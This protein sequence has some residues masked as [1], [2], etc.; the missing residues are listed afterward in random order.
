MLTASRRLS[1]SRNTIRSGRLTFYLA[2]AAIVLLAA[3]LRL[4]ALDFADVRFDEASALQQAL[5]IAQGRLQLLANFSGSVL[6]HPPAYLYIHGVAVSGDARLSCGVDISRLAGCAGDC[7]VHV[8]LSA[9]LFR[10]HGVDR[11]P[12]LRHSAVGHS[13]FAQ[14]RHRRHSPA[15]RARRARLARSH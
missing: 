8:D 9:A 10:A 13:V 6:N 7:A 1:L 14:H 2:T 4:H 3:V 12:A 15:R 11:R 5:S